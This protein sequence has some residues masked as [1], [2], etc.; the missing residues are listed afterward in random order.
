MTFPDQHH[1]NRVCEALWDRPG[2]GA[3]VMVGSGFSRSA[4]AVRPGA[5]PLPMLDEIATSLSAQ[6]YPDNRADEK[7]PP[8]R[9]LR[10]AQAYEAEF[11]PP[12]LHATLTR[13]VADDDF[14]PGNAHK[15]LLKLPWADVFTTN[16]DTLL[17]RATRSVPDRAYSIVRRKDN[18]PRRPR[19]RIVKLHGS[20]PDAPLILTEE[21]YRTYPARFSPFVNTV[22]QSM[23][24]T[25]ML[26]IG[27]SGNDPNFL[28]WSGWIRDNL[29]DAAPTIYLAGFLK[30]SPP[31]RKMLQDRNVD[32]IDLAKHPRAD[33]WTDSHDS[34]TKW[35]LS[36]LECG[37]PYNISQWPLPRAAAFCPEDDPL[38]VRN[39]SAEPIREQMRPTS[40]IAANARLEE[41]RR[42]LR[43]WKHNRECY[44]RWLVPPTG[45]R[46][47]QRLVTEHWTPLILRELPDLTATERLDAIREITWR[48]ELTLERLPSE[49]EAV[50][51]EL[52]ESIDCD[53]RTVEGNRPDDV[54]WPVVREA[55]REVAL[56]LLTAARFRFDRDAFD[57]RVN[58]LDPFLGDDVEVAHR[59]RHERCLW[60]LWSLDHATLSELLDAW[61]TD[62]G[63]PAWTIRK[64]ALL[65]E[66][67][68][69]KEANESIIGALDDI[70]AMPRA[71][72]D[73]A[74]PSREGWALSSLVQTFAD[75]FG[76]L[77]AR[78][79]NVQERR[80]KLALT[81]CDP[82]ADIRRLNEELSVRRRDRR[83]IAFDLGARVTEWRLESPSSSSAPAYRAIRLTEVAGLSPSTPS[84][85]VITIASQLV[86]RA[87]EALTPE[88]SAIGI[89]QMIRVTTSDSDKAF[90]RTVSRSRMASLPSESAK[91][92]AQ[93]VQAALKH[94]VSCLSATDGE[95]RLYGWRRAGVAIESLSW[96]VLRLDASSVPSLFDLAIDL[97]T[98]HTVVSW[99]SFLHRSVRNLLRRCWDSLD[100][101]QRA[102][103][104]LDVLEMPIVEL[105]RFADDSDL[106]PEPGAILSWSLS[107]PPRLAANESRWGAVVRTLIRGM[108]SD[109]QAR[110]RSAS[111]VA[112]IA[113]WDRL[114]KTETVEVAEA[115]WAMVGDEGRGL[116]EGTLLPD[117]AFI[118]LPEPTVGMGRARFGRKWLSGDIANVRL[119]RRDDEQSKGGEVDHRDSTR[120]DNILWQAGMA[121]KFM[122]RRAKT[123]EFTDTEK[124]YL[125]GVTQRWAET[126][127]PDL[128][129]LPELFRGGSAQPIRNAC[130]GLQ[131]IL[132]EIEIRSDL[133][134]SL[135]AKVPKMID[136]G[137]PA[138]GMLSG[139]ASASEDF[140]EKVALLMA[141]GLASDD[142]E[143]GESAMKSL[144]QWMRFASDCALGLVAPPEHLICEI[145]V[146]VAT[147]RRT[148]LAQ[149]LHAAKWVFED[150]SEDARGAIRD[151]V[152]KGLGYLTEEL[153]Y[154][155]EDPFDGMVDVPL[156][157]WRSIQVARAMAG[158]G[159]GDDPVIGR[160]LQLGRDDPLPEVRH[161][162]NKGRA[163]DPS[164]GVAG[165]EWRGEDADEG[166]ADA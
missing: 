16:W 65:R 152:L 148:I 85:N 81:K 51:G 84:S 129:S 4:R 24:E 53:E 32:A 61:D 47:R 158:Q 31:E 151:L 95:R 93:D 123:L 154:D 68:R 146:S 3:S 164:I 88:D 86:E 18:I 23:M 45:A 149:A 33:D 132:T 116:P 57:R 20:L 140:R 75:D 17:E 104:V 101:E 135:Y 136:Q 91:S 128:Q 70:R 48:Y 66:I 78:R 99:S 139:I 113:L 72:S 25:A 71:D 55:W 165:T 122:R 119:T 34:A 105:D 114:E 147:R 49:I 76:S 29:G 120:A 39:V 157:R 108:R 131:W 94:A 107:P 13:M 115:L 161:V 163:G 142:H 14:V 144:H 22:Q 43:I 30:L 87:A 97:Y 150:G 35:L 121:M 112:R 126:A 64:S 26:L 59:V 130:L 2:P 102:E 118:L 60:V 67:G 156:A 127:V 96:L 90:M 7:V 11:R 106:W 21:D 145:G 83:P 58:A 74:A 92:L 89:R 166:T 38:I 100:D 28:H 109:G 77:E 125:V 41:A 82:T 44:P 103:R 155:R 10:L 138:Y 1:M 98:N 36:S 46:N 40:A 42:V 8:E 162:V 73:L 160:W 56:V 110:I 137:I 63:D 6:L 124:E 15:R 5:Q 9:V 52:L 141:T 143:K 117:Y 134:E 79:T 159:L 50:A 19:P 54:D 153:R 111:R 80:D 133:A 27:F 62:D 69:N 37:Q 12:A